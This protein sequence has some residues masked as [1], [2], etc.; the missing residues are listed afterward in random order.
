[1]VI[2]AAEDEPIE[3]PDEIATFITEFVG[4]DDVT[5]HTS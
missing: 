3:E 4:D 1:M 5:E 2:E